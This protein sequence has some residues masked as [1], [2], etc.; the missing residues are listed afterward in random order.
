MHKLKFIKAWGGGGVLYREGN[1]V[2]SSGT[3]GWGVLESGS[4]LTEVEEEWSCMDKR[5]F[6]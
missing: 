3:F 5:G 2:G 6:T 4:K 1:R